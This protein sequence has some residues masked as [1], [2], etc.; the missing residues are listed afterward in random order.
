MRGRPKVADC[1]MPRSEAIDALLAE[2][3]GQHTVHA[4]ILA[5]QD[6]RVLSFAPRPSDPE[7]AIATEEW[8]TETVTAVSTM[9]RQCPGEAVSM[10][11]D[12]NDTT[13]QVDYHLQPVGPCILVLLFAHASGI[14]RVRAVA[15]E[16]APRIA[17][18]LVPES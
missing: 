3:V 13:H 10:R 16:A 8:A 6:N 1:V 5:T 7:E 15:G 17:E 9:L 14:G 18:L 12:A 2:L 4:A 11:F